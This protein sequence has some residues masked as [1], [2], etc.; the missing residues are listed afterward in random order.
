M[1]ADEASAALFVNKPPDGTDALHLLRVYMS[2]Q[3]MRP[4]GSKSTRRRRARRAHRAAARAEAR[5]AEADGDAG[6]G[7]AACVLACARQ[8]LEDHSERPREITLAGDAQGI[9][10][11]CQESWHVDAQARE[12]ECGHCFHPAC[13]AAWL[14]HYKAEC[15]LCRALVVEC[16][17]VPPPRSLQLFLQ[18]G[19]HGHTL[20]A[21]LH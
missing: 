1:G 9:C 11:V 10:A 18:N 17:T 3:H 7:E 19:A 16:R 15:P 21:V 8:R 4:A 14:H 6:A 12:L 13:V 2:T 20:R 5:E